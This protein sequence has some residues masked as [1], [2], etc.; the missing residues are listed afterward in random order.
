[1][2]VEGV[3][4]TE[5]REMKGE[6]SPLADGELLE[7]DAPLATSFVLPACLGEEQYVCERPGG[8]K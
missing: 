6:P 8:S 7:S 3:Y 2:L 1:M 4:S 5:R